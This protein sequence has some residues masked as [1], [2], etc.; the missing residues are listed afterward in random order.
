MNERFGNLPGYLVTKI[1]K[2]LEKC[3]TCRGTFSWHNMFSTSLYNVH[4]GGSTLS[5]VSGEPHL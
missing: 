5:V 1:W 2:G 3:Y 4:V